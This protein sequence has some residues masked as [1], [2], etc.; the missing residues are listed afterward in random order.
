MNGYNIE[1]HEVKVL[2]LKLKNYQM[3][4]PANGNDD[5]IYW[6]RRS[7]HPGEPPIVNKTHG[8]RHGQRFI[9]EG[10]AVLSEEGTLITWVEFESD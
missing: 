7:S 3:K 6:K 1:T 10:F 8:F 4:Y 5:G 2:K 9:K